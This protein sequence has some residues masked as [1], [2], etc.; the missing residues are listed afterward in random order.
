MGTRNVGKIKGKKRRKGAT[1]GPSS[2]LQPLAAVGSIASVSA[3]G[4]R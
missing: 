1:A 2:G 3:R 4:A